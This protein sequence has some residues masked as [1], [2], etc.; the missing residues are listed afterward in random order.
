[1]TV[2]VMGACAC[3]KSSVG[4]RLARELGATFIEGDAFHPAASVARMAAGIAITDA[5]AP[6]ETLV[7]AALAQLQVAPP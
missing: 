4:E 5:D 2:V 1:M 6:P 7:Q 3:G